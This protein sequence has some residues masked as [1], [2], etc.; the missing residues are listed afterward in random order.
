MIATLTGV[1]AEKTIDM[2]VLDVSGVG[3]GI[4]VT[5]EDYGRLGAG[6]LTKLYLH[7]HIRESA[8]D[9]YGFLLLDTKQLFEQLLDVT[10]VGPKMA[11]NILSIGTANDVRGWI[12]TGDVKALQKASGVGKRVAERVVV[13]LKDK[14]GLEGVDLGAAGLLQSERAITGDEAA[15]ALVALGYTPQDAA[16]ALTHV[17]KDLPTEERIKQ[18][19]KQKG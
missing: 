2:V 4:L 10:G 13:E 17:G 3:Y 15:E 18:A 7:E 16:K 5:N 8:Y 6:D 14:V 11:L 19:L 12:A 1:V 9:L